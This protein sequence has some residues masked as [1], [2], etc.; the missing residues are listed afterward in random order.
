MVTAGTVLVEVIPATGIDRT[1]LKV[2]VGNKD[3]SSAFETRGDGRFVG[4]VTDLPLGTSSITVDA[5]GI[6]TSALTVTN[7]PNSG[8]LLYGPRVQPW[9]CD[10]GAVDADCNRP[11]TYEYYY[12]STNPA[13]TNLLKYNLQAPATNVAQTTTSDGKSVPFIVRLETGVQNRDYYNI[14]VLFDPSKP[15]TSF[16]PQSAWNGG[17]LFI[18]GVGCGQGYGQSG[19]L[20]PNGALAKSRALD[21]Y[22]LSRGFIVSTVALNDAGHNC[23]IP[24]EAEGQLMAKEHII[25]NYGEPQFV[26]GYGA[27]GGAIAQHWL[28]NGYPGLYDG[29]IGRVA[30]ADYGT[31]AVF[32]EDCALVLGY[33]TKYGTSWTDA[34]KAA[35]GGFLSPKVCEEAVTFYGFE[36]QFNPSTRNLIN[37]PDG[38]FAQA[39]WSD[40]ALGGCDAPLE[41]IYSATSNPNGI[42]CTLQDYAVGVFGKRPDGF[43]NRPYSNIGVQYGLLG[44]LNGTLSAEQFVDLNEKVGSHS[45]DY[46]FQPQRVAADPDGLANVYRSSWF[47]QTNN[48]DQVAIIHL[49]PFDITGVHNQFRSWSVRARL[50]RSTGGHGNMAIWYQA[51]SQNEAYDV[52]QAWL[53]AVKGDKSMRTLKEKI[54]ANRPPNANDRCGNQDGTNKSMLECTGYSDLSSRVGAGGPFADDILECQLKPLNQSD[55]NIA[56]TSS[57]WARLQAA[58]PSG[59]CDYTKP[60]KEQQPGV[61][62][63]TYMN[64]D[65]SPIYGGAPLP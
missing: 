43:A 1:R 4:L 16:Q 47:N 49:R 30:F 37:T 65:G 3:V 64:A 57:Q 48:L 26:F 45:I 52:M 54:V 22:A 2:H 28:A 31:V 60:G 62:W 24:V 8:P 13:N 5:E 14:A 20:M 42:R 46:S 58:F 17:V 33:L 40:T 23:I 59:A 56:F 21:V 11:A 55:Y 34:Q 15:W 19:Y 50:D 27:S 61:A 10:P 35:A 9:R 63:L 36:N 41:L 18:H 6:R 25:K 12:K 29:I 7:H 53:K 38:R 32:V 39:S 44:L 51:G